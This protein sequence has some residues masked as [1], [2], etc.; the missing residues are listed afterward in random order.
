MNGHFILVR[1]REEM[2][3]TE[4]TRALTF[5]YSRILEMNSQFI[6]VAT[7]KNVQKCFT[8]PEFLKRTANLLWSLPPNVCKNKTKL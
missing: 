1:T 8:T 7:L 2:A 6:L 5:L 3:K 4:N